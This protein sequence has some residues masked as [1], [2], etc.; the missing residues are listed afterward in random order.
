MK[1]FEVGDPSPT[2]S[3][4]PLVELTE[5]SNE[6]DPA[7]PSSAVAAGPCRLSLSLDRPEGYTAAEDPDKGWVTWGVVNNTLISNVATPFTLSTG[8]KVWVKVTTNG[9]VPVKVL[10]AVLEGG[11]A[12]PEDAGGSAT[13]PPTT[14]YFLLGQVGGAG[15]LADPW[16][17]LST[18]C[19]NLRYSAVASGYSCVLASPG[20]P[21]ATPPIPPSP[22]GVKTDYQMKWERF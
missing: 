18:G 14:A 7:Q 1:Q 4:F 22:G 3:A 20:D 5:W 13:T 17:V 16:S 6:A 8:L 2:R 11:S 9:A 12:V 19:G 15:T 21:G 10:S